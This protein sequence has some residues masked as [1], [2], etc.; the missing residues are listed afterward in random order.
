MRNIPVVSETASKLSSNDSQTRAALFHNEEIDV[1]MMLNASCLRLE[2][3][4]P[5]QIL[6]F[7]RQFYNSS[8]IEQV[9][10]GL[11]SDRLCAF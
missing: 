8:E 5:A 4:L 3:S 1:V 6:L 11:I 7:G 9:T 10:G 2:V